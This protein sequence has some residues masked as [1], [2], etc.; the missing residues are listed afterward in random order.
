MPTP[1]TVEEFVDSYAAA[2]AA[3]D[4]GFLFDRLHPAAV[5]GFGA[6]LCR[7]WIDGEILALGDYRLTGAVEGPLEQSFTTPAGTGL[8]E[9]AFRAPVSFVFQGQEFD[10][11][12]GFALVD[13]EMRWLGQ[14]R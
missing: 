3:G 2:I 8:I 4:V 10:A 6:D 7:A 14:C 9:N 12:A 1:E 11:F 5:G 13:G